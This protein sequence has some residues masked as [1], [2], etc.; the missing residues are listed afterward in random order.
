M[1]S[2]NLEHFNLNSYSKH[3]RDYE[4]SH[5]N[6]KSIIGLPEKLKQLILNLIFYFILL[7]QLHHFLPPHPICSS[8]RFH[9][10]SGKRRT[11]PMH[12]IITEKCQ[13]GWIHCLPFVHVSRPCNRFGWPILIAA[14]RHWDF[15]TRLA[16]NNARWCWW[17]TRANAIHE[18]PGIHK[19]RSASCTHLD[20]ATIAGL[21]VPRVF[22]TRTWINAYAG[23]RFMGQYIF[24]RFFLVLNEAVIFV[25]INVQ[26]NVCVLVVGYLSYIHTGEVIEC[27]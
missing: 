6:L 16:S 15:N 20:T 8:W 26:V 17:H 11:P 7:F 9:W 3:L 10:S 5:E 24:C 22:D 1:F 21:Y 25:C 4:Q 14:Q 12:V 13:C 19:C 18:F 2:W 27:K 23:K